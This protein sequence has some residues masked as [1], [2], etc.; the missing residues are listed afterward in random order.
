[1]HARVEAS[2]PGAQASLLCCSWPTEKNQAGA[3]QQSLRQAGSGGP[4]FVWG[5]GGAW[6]R[7]AARYRSRRVVMAG[8][9]VAA[10]G[11]GPLRWSA[12]QA[13]KA[14]ATVPNKEAAG[15]VRAALVY[16]RT[17]FRRGTAADRQRAHA[18]LSMHARHPLS[19]LGLAGVG[20]CGAFLLTASGGPFADF[21]AADLAGGK[22]GAG[23]CAIELVDGSEDF[24]ST[25]ASMM[26]KGLDVDRGLL[27]CLMRVLIR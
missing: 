6:N 22:R 20:V 4:R 12:V 25:S 10:R 18:I 13:C 15:H 19:R 8:H 2:C 3:L 16:G 7:M 11:R 21:C 1:V 27:G 14:G 5:E 17:R 9:L 26:N 23:L 24:G